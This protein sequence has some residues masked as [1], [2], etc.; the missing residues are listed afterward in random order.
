ME[1]EEFVKSTLVEVVRGVTSAQEEMR[2]SGA[3]VNPHM[4]A[5]SKEHSIGQPEGF[6]G[7]HVDYMNF[8][9]AVTVQSEQEAKG[10]GGIKVMGLGVGVDASTGSSTS[11]VSRISFKVPLMFPT[12]ND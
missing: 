3:R 11:N 8:D 1:L 10:G 9:I 4:R 7:Q 12:Q 6:G 2:G 5:I